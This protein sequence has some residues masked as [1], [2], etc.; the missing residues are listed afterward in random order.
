MLS[1][2]TGI[3]C[4]L[5]EWRGEGTA[6]GGGHCFL[7]AGGCLTGVG[8][9][10]GITGCESG[11]EECDGGGESSMRGI[12]ASMGGSTG[13]LAG[14]R[15]GR[16]MGLSHLGNCTSENLACAA[17]KR[18]LLGE[19]INKK[20]ASLPGATPKYTISSDLGARLS[21]RRSAGRKTYAV[22]PKMRKWSTR[23]CL[24]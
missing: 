21:A 18:T 15:V 14:A 20:L 4:S 12:G 13:T 10:G 8:A 1:G 2:R 9:T 23:G 22:Q 16:F 5:P 6:G 7:G 19:H 3:L 24:L 11:D 17:V